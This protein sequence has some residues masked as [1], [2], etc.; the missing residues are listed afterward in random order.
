MQVILTLAP[1]KHDPPI[2][3]I[4]RL[5]SSFVPAHVSPH[6]SDADPQDIRA[7]VAL[8]QG[9]HFLTTFHPELTQDDRFHEY[10]VTECVLRELDKSI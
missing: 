3:I 2:S 1:T 9:R 4:A 5:P 8:R 6:H 7:V 10:F